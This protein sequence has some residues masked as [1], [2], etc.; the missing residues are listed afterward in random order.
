MFS[1]TKSQI[2][3]IKNRNSFI[4][5]NNFKCYTF[6]IKIDFINEFI[7]NNVILSIKKN[8]Y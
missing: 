2:S 7:I 1:K 4:L 5:L 6:K 3:T 8:C